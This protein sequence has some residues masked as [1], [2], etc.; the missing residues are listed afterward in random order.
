MAPVGRSTLGWWSAAAPKAKA[1]DDALAAS[2]NPRRRLILKAVAQVFG[3]HAPDIDADKRG[4]APVALA[5]Q[6]A[7]YVTHVVFGLSLAH[8]GRLFDRDRTTVAHAC[9]VVEDMRDDPVFD[10]IVELL[11][12]IVPAVVLPRPLL[13]HLS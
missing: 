3:V 11:E 4:R 6:V 8:T 10:R 9:G 13:Q 1:E 12:S 2:L 5:R 7:M